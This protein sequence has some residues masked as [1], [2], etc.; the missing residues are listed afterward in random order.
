M[1]L[2][3]LNI[4]PFL[5]PDATGGVAVQLCEVQDEHDLDEEAG[6]RAAV[7]EGCAALGWERTAWDFKFPHQDSGHGFMLVLCKP[8]GSTA[9]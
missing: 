1:R 2:G 4:L 6:F 3:F 8:K 9:A 5:D 7:T